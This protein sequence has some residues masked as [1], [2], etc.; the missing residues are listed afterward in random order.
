MFFKRKN[1][2]KVKF[3][4]MQDGK[5]VLY[6]TFTRECEAMAYAKKFT[7]QVQIDTLVY[8]DD[9]LISGWTLTNTTK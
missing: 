6:A 2:Y 7:E 9:E 5:L 3:H 4:S 1:E 8:K